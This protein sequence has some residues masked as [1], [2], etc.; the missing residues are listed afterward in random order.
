[1]AQHNHL[2]KVRNWLDKNN[3]K[4]SETVEYEKGALA[5]LVVKGDRVEYVTQSRMGT[6][7]YREYLKEHFGGN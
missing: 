5:L 3:I 1:M 2:T 7:E 6:K 4:V